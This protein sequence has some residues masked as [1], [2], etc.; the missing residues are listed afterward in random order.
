MTAFCVVL[1]AVSLIVHVDSDLAC[2]ND[3]DADCVAECVCICCTKATPADDSRGVV[4]AEDP[5]F[6]LAPYVPHRGRLPVADIFRPPIA[7]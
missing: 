1:A 5:S 2:H 4:L 6:S 7:S 3:G